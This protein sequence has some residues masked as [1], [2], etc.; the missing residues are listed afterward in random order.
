[1]FRICSIAFGILVAF[2][3]ALGATGCRNMDYSAEQTP[4]A[5]LLA[6]GVAVDA[7]LNIESQAH[8][9]VVSRAEGNESH[10]E[11]LAVLVFD[12]NGTLQSRQFFKSI[13]TS[14]PV[15]VRTV[16][17]SNM[18]VA[19][20]ANYASVEGVEEM[21]LELNDYGSLTI[22]TVNCSGLPNSDLLMTGIR[23]TD[24]GSRTSLKMELRYVSSK[25]TMRVGISDRFPKDETLEVTGVELGSIPQKGGLFFS[26]S[27]GLTYTDRIPWPTDGGT[28]VVQ[29]FECTYYMP[30][31]NA[32]GR[33]SIA[34]PA[35]AEPETAS[36]GHMFKRHY[37]PKNASYAVIHALHRKGAVTRRMEL[38]IY[39]GRDN[40]Y[41]YNV[42]RAECHTYT[43]RIHGFN[44]LDMDTNIEYEAID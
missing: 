24:I 12:N 23:N 22:L 9:T 19:A 30:E 17:G 6:P 15:T 13:D 34:P 29:G 10:I 35:G 39:F 44:Q 32:G 7:F 42:G 27:W 26:V 33:R 43:V 37:A 18:R 16:S 11:S 4:D 31:N 36:N 28:D 40:A 2:G 14:R 8:R 5:P 21:L 3:V 38:Y 20:V 1:M 25:V 41:D